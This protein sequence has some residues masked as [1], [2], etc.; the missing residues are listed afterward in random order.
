MEVDVRN[1]ALEVGTNSSSSNRHSPAQKAIG[2]RGCY[3]T[4]YNSLH[5]KLTC[6]LAHARS[7]NCVRLW[8]VILAGDPT[9]LDCSRQL[10]RLDRSCLHFARLAIPTGRRARLTTHHQSICFPHK[11]TFL[12]CV[13]YT[14]RIWYCPFLSILGVRSLSLL[15]SQTHHQLATLLKMGSSVS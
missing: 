2:L 11:Y 9:T 8:H 13:A 5:S 1:V 12:S 3:F 10:A 15:T 6:A 14:V 7:T 4:A